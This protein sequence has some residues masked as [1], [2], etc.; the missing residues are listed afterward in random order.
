MNLMKKIKAST[1][2]YS[3]ADLGPIAIAFVILTVI[4]AVGAIVL[5]ELNVSN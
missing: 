4:V 3:I 5:G 2:G 1:K